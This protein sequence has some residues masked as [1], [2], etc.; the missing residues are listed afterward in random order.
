M[1]RSRIMPLLLAAGMLL[2]IHNGYIA[3]WQGEDPEPVQVFP[4]KASMLP[5]QD[6]S[7][8]SEGISIHSSDELNRLLEDYLS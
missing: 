6:Q 2:G 7:R 4:Y 1:K 5:Q 8:L 3:L